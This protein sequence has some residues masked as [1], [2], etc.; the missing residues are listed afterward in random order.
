MS[1]ASLTV[2]EAAGSAS[3][4]STNG[5]PF[6]LVSTAAMAAVAAVLHWRLFK[7][8]ITV[9][10]N[11]G[12]LAGMATAAVGA[13]TDSGDL[14]LLTLFAYDIAV[15]ALAMWFDT[16][17][18]A[19]ITRRTD[20]AFWLHL[21]AAPLIDHPVYTL[22]GLSRPDAGA[23]AAAAITV[24]AKRCWRS[25]STGGPCWCRRCST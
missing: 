8:P 19:R 5:P 2:L 11:A 3:I 14:I 22:A 6:G 17:D 1:H 25:R 24:Y 13:L 15:F 9:A 7:V 10:A 12:A 18:R 16:R 4:H 23:G 20:M 21:L